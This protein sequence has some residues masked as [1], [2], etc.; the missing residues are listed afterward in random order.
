VLCIG[1]HQEIGDPGQ[2]REIVVGF[3]KAKTTIAG[4]DCLTGEHVNDQDA[5]V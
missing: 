1:T 2:E 4:P 3:G 5:L